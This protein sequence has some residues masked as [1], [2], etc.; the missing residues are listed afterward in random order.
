MRILIAD[1]NAAI[2][3]GV[4]TI[5]SGKENWQVCGEAVNGEEAIQKAREL[6]PDL[7]LLDI[8]MPGLSGMEAARVLSAEAVQAKILIIS[9]HD[10]VQLLPRVIEAGAYGC[11]DK[12]RLAMDLVPAIEE[13]EKK[14][15]GRQS[16]APLT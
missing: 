14:F 11:V 5:L 16:I 2:R 4:T 1:D 12:N 10:P 9:Q 15:T 3:R 6:R 13:I 7:I 8:S